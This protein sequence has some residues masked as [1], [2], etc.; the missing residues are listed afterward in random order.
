MTSR[1]KITLETTTWH[2]KNIISYY[3]QLCPSS[4]IYL[5]H[6]ALSLSLSLCL[7]LSLSLS[8]FLSLSLCIYSI[9]RV[10]MMIISIHLGQS[11]FLISS[12]CICMCMCM[13]TFLY[14]YMYICACMYLQKSA[15]ASV[16][17]SSDFLLY[18]FICLHLSQF[19]YCPSCSSFL[20]VFNWLIVSYLL[21]LEMTMGATFS[22]SSMRSRT[23]R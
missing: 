9:K 10:L 7:C 8:L 22:T 18:Q 4:P 16:S 5:Y 15:R 2:A 23:A 20:L 6:S 21:P 1:M 3:L 12:L 14:E 17:Q 19:I 11:V 13:C